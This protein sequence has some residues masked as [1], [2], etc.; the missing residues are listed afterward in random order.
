MDRTDEHLRL[1]VIFHYILAGMTLLGLV[2]IGLHYWAVIT[3]I[4]PGSWQARADVQGIAVLSLVRGVYAVMAFSCV[5]GIVLNVLAAQ[6]LAAR[7]QWMLCA[8][9]SGIN[10]LQVPLGTF[11]GVATLVLI[12]KAEVRARFRS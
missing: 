11:L 1:L 10:C 3:F 5:L 6:A 2:F 12:N 4:N 9:V 8:V 7:R